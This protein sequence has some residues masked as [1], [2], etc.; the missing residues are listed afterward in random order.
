MG[1]HLGDTIRQSSADIRLLWFSVFA[2]MVAFGLTNQIL[3][4]YLKSLEIPESMIGIFMSLTMIGDSI[5]SYLLTWNAN[6]IGTRRVM[7]IGSFLMFFCGLFFASGTGDFRIL[8]FAA[9][10]GVISPSGGDTGPFKTIEEAVLAKLTPPNHRPEV[11]AVHGTLAAIGSSFGNLGAGFLVQTLVSRYK[12]TYR[13]AYC[14]SF[15]PFCIISLIKYATML[16][17]SRKCEPNYILKFERVQKPSDVPQIS[18]DHDCSSSTTSTYPSE[19]SPLIE[20]T[21]EHQTLTGLSPHSQN[22]LLKLLVPFMIDSFG[23]GFMPSAWVVYYFKMKY[24]AAASVLGMIFCATDLIQSASAVPSAWFSK[25]MGPLKSTLAVQIPC[26]IFFILIPILGSTLP[27]ATVLY[28]L[29]QA[30]T[31]FDV[32][33]RQILL[34][35]L[36]DSNDLPKVLG[37]VNIGK[38]IARSISPGFTGFLAENGYLWVC[39]LISGSL[40]ILANIILAIMFKGVDKIVEAKQSIEHE[41]ER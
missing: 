29:N 41:I 6:A 38:Q 15:I 39:F 20:S 27:R 33:P 32:V 28:L 36:I 31:A 10:F 21:I 22:I 34:T 2:R 23:Y 35:S 24:M 12:L 9:I 3:T 1:M 16:F 25:H 26:G 19:S 30:T 4:L 7:R 11:Y 13:E 40:L 14:R 18:E 17:M 5:L 8:L 37:T